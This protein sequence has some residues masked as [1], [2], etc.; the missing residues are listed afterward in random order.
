MPNS[1]TSVNTAPIAVSKRREIDHLVGDCTSKVA[2]SPNS[3]NVVVNHV[4]SGSSGYGN[5]FAKSK[6]KVAFEPSR[7][8][9]SGVAR[10]SVP[11]PKSNSISSTFPSAY[12]GG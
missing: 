3:P 9:T 5:G 8:G 4:S 12:E 10:T 7:N 6:E 11:P 1:S 2:P